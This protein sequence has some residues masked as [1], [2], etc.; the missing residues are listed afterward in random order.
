M[1]SLFHRYCWSIFISFSGAILL[2]EVLLVGNMQHYNT[3]LQITDHKINKNQDTFPMFRILQGRWFLV[4]ILRDMDGEKCRKCSLMKLNITILCKSDPI[5]EALEK[6]TW[7]R[8]VSP[9]L[10]RRKFIHGCVY[11]VYV[12]RSYYFQK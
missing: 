11:M 6:N 4:E 3:I 8:T 1:H 5:W 7:S 10:S 9:S 12:V 2:D